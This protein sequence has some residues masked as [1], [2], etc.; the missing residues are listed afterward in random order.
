MS[1]TPTNVTLIALLLC[2]GFVVFTSI[3]AFILAAVGHRRQLYLSFGILCLLASTFPLSEYLYYTQATMQ[4]AREV[5]HWRP[6]QSLSLIPA[7]F[8]FIVQYAHPGQGRRYTKWLAVL[9]AVSAMTL[10][11]QGVLEP[12]LDDVLRLP[13]MIA[14]QKMTVTSAIV[15]LYAGLV[16]TWGLYTAAGVYRR[17]DRRTAG[18]LGASLGLM[19]VVLI[20]GVLVDLGILRIFYFTGFSFLG[21]VLLMTIGLGLELR[22][23]NRHIHSLAFRDYLTGLPNRADLEERLAVLLSRRNNG[24]DV[25]GA[26]LQIGLDNFKTI[27]DTLG[28]RIG[29]RILKEVAFRLS[30]ACHDSIAIR[31]GSDD[32]ALL[33]PKLGQEHDYAAKGARQAA[34]GVMRSLAIPFVLNADIVEITVGIG[35]VI[36]PVA[37][38]TEVDILRR[39]DLALQHAKRAGPGEVQM[40]DMSMQVEMTARMRMERALQQAQQ[41]SEFAV[42]FQPQVAASG[43]VV[44]A[45]VLLRW[46]DEQGRFIPPAVFVPLAER[47]GLIRPIGEWVLKQACEYIATFNRV[48]P[49]FTGH[50]SVNVSASQFMQTDYEQSVRRQVLD[51]GINPSRLTLEITESAFIGDMED[52]IEKINSLHAFGVRFS[53]D[54][55]GTGYSSLSYLRRLPVQELKI[56]Q[57]FVRNLGADGRDLHMIRT[58]IEISRYMGLDVVAEGVET[59]LQRNTLEAMNCWALQGYL[60]SPP[61]DGPAFL[62]WVRDHR[63]GSQVS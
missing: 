26:L 2:S 54:D 8:W 11:G 47:C 1:A 29:D 34:A 20:I 37:S 62:E 12:A 23:R 14:G 43:E 50:V 13:G 24:S 28:H 61:L 45:E 60:L 52:A 3:Q 31:L 7:L 46:K 9:I 21:L 16:L 57:A 32:F 17:G 35:I 5:V 63:Q 6:L 27:N 33:M 15:R 19:V 41:N 53:I 22:D 38:D 10:F 56:D 49:E 55:F 44:G 40:Y 36:F 48:V 25:K 58:I 4:D 59:E 18:F 30:A 51:T 39:A 42:Y